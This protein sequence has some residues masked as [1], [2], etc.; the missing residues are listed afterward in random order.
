LHGDAEVPLDV[1]QLVGLEVAVEPGW[2]VLAD[3]S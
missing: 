3:D 1:E 2:R